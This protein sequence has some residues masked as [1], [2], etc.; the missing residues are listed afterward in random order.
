MKNG[1]K[2]CR[3]TPYNLLSCE[4]I[5]LSL[6]AYLDDVKIINGFPG[7]RTTEVSGICKTCNKEYVSRYF[8]MQQYFKYHGSGCPEC[9]STNV[10]QSSLKEFLKTLCDNVE[11]NN[12]TIVKFNSNRFKELDLYCDKYSFAIEYNGLVWHSEKYG[13][14]KFYHWD[15]TK[16]CKDQGITLLH[17]WGDKYLSNPRIYYSIIKAKLGKIDNKI[18]ARKTELKD[19]TK[20]ELEEFF[21]NNH[22]D[23][24]TNCITGWGLFYKGKL[25]EC[26]SVRRVNSQNKKYKGYLEIARQATLLDHLV[27]GGESKL[28]NV[29]EQYAKSNNFLGILNYVSCDFGGFPKQKWK[30]TYQGVSDISYFYTDCSRRVSRQKLQ[31]RKLGQS[32]KD[33]AEELGLFKVYGTPNLVYSLRF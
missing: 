7:N 13:K 9:N 14:D 5:T 4:D 6:S 26:I 21:D 18:F 20:R 25:V 10:Q 24:H 15:K 3:C 12:R 33:L 30:F 27:V 22:L 2:S 32:E 16:A 1:L 23:G 19:L 17:I 28:L 11:E 31:K 8:N 29:V